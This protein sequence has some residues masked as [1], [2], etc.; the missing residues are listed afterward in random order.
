MDA[1][2]IMQVAKRAGMTAEK[3]REAFE[4]GA[5]HPE[6]SAVRDAMLAVAQEERAAS[7]AS[8]HGE[9]APHKGSAFLGCE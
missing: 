7:K 8:A 4:A 6:W 1:A 9:S 2:K 3:V 5:A